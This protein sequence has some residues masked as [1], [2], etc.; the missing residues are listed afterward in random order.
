[1]SPKSFRTKID[2]TIDDCEGGQASTAT[3]GKD[4]LLKKWIAHA[5]KVLAM[6]FLEFHH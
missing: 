5:S 3:K 2:E 6:L 1:M 4:P